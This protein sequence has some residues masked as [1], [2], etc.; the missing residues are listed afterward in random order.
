MEKRVLGRTGYKSTLMTLGGSAF[1]YPMNRRKRDRFMKFCIDH[2]VNQ[3]DV[4]PAISYGDAEL[5]LGTWV[6]EYRGS[7]F[8]GCKTEKR[9]KDEAAEALRNSLKRLQTDYFDLYQLHGLDDPRELRIALG[10]NGAIQAILE[11]KEQ[12]LVKYIGI[13][14]HNP[15]NIMRAL[16]AFDFDTILLPVNYV[17]RAHPEP[18]NDYRPVLSLAQKRN[19]GII[20]MKSIAKG[21]WLTPPPR[22][23]NTQ[24]QPFETK[25]E[26]EE[27]LRFALSQYVTTVTTSSDT[28]LARLMIDAAEH[29]TPLG[30]EEQEELLLRASKYQPLFPL[31]KPYLASSY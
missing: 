16:K 24:Y 9:T 21:P 26:V 5:I 27:A 31:Y 11:A 7:L 1:F 15:E 6:K 8:L 3:I 25:K 23:H 22:S 10:E 14:S 13:T 30:E 20:V 17:L 29:F 28:Q 4:A 2:G 18:K 12:G 19:L